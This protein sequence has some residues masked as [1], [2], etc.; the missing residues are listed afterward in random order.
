M[1]CLKVCKLCWSTDCSHKEGYKVEIDD[2]IVDIIISLNKKGYSTLYCC[3]GH[4]RVPDDIYI[5]FNRW[6]CPSIEKFNINE[7]WK[8]TEYN[9]TLRATTPR[10]IRTVEQSREFLRDRREELREWLKRI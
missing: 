2:S 4:D 3:G 9:A 10:S 8:Y 1:I 6:R 7:N 5:S